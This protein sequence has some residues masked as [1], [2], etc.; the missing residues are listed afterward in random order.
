MGMVLRREGG[1]AMKMPTLLVVLFVMLLAS[2]APR[3]GPAYIYHRDRP[4][5]IE[6]K[7]FSFRPD[8]FVVL[9]NQ[10]PIILLLKN[11]DDRSHNFTLQAPDR[12]LILSRDLEP[13]VSATVSMESLRSGNN[14]LFYCSFHRH[15]GMEGM[16]MVD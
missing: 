16:L 7:D 9:K 11:T 4:I 10:S 3:V 2:C 6:L 1:A 13:N 14:Y 15:R 12:S 5:E 8:H